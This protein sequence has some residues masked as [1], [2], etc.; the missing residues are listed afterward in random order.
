MKKATQ[1]K[2][3]LEK[4]I[5]RILPSENPNPIKNEQ[6]IMNLLF[7]SNFNKLPVKDSILIFLHIEEKFK[8]QIADIKSERKSDISV[9]NDFDGT[10]QSDKQESLK[11][12]IGR[13]IFELPVK[14][15]EVVEFKKAE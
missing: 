12:L 14:E 1:F 7:Y 2:S 11:E 9:I 13:P 5:S 10:N 4:L 3:W 8:K 6:E 15:F